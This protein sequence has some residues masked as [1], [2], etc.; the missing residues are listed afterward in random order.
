MV[1]P[2]DDESVKSNDLPDPSDD[3]EWLFLH[4]LSSPS[5]SSRL[6]NMHMN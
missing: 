6:T 1:P 3:G 2:S 4:N 5:S